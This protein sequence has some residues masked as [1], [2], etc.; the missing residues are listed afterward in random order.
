MSVEFTRIRHQLN[1]L[2]KPWALSGSMAIKFHANHLGIP[3]HRQPNDF[4]IVIREQDLSLFIDA[5][6]RIGYKLKT[7]PP[8]HFTH[9]KMSHG[10]FTIDLLAAD[11]RLAPNIQ[12]T[13][14]VLYNKTPV[15]KINH[16]IRQKNRILENSRNNVARQ[17]R[18]FLQRL[19][20]VL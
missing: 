10:R 17:N 12:G 13:N 18:N 8:I 4:D 1:N 19:Q 14:I 15:I 7:S 16:L 9:L 6:S 5:L 2:R 20:Q 3:M 11:S